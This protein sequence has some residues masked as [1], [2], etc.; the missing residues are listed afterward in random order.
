MNANLCQGSFAILE[1]LPKTLEDKPLL[2]DWS[3]SPKHIAVLY[4][5]VIWDRHR[6]PNINI[7]EII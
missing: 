5:S 6:T 4:F 3:G 7:K 1:F 2:T